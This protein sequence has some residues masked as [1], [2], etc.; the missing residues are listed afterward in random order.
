M[1][2]A[3]P[4]GGGDA[5]GAPTADKHRRARKSSA[6]GEPRA[7]GARGAAPRG[8]LELA[9]RAS[10]VPR[11]LAPFAALA[12]RGKATRVSAS[13]RAAHGLLAS[14]EAR[15]SVRGAKLALCGVEVERLYPYVAVSQ[16][17]GVGERAA[18]TTRG[19]ARTD[20]KKQTTA[21]SWSDETFCVSCPTDLP[22]EAGSRARAAALAGSGDVRVH[23]RG[24]TKAAARKSPRGRND[25]P[26]SRDSRGRSTRPATRRASAA[27]VRAWRA[28]EAQAAAAAAK[29]S[30]SIRRRRRVI[31]EVS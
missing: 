20:A 24:G 9:L 29:A 5:F 27:A 18:R 10:W 30:G 8:A 17:D 31:G 19:A 13:L 14:C 23:Q 11:G 21:P 26:A 3:P 4:A 15:I 6:P 2:A 25:A 16:G 12:S 1:A 28:R 22:G 7:L